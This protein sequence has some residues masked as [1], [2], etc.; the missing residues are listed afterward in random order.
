MAKQNPQPFEKLLEEFRT[1]R[2]KKDIDILTKKA[3]NWFRLNVDKYVKKKETTYSKGAELGTPTF[4]P[5]VGRFYLYKYDPKWKDELP[6]YDIMPLVLITSVT[7]NGWYGINFHYMPPI[8]RYKIMSEMYKIQSNTVWI[9]KKK[10][11]LSWAAAEK[12]GA[13]VGK[14][15]ELNHSIKQ[16]L[17]GHCRSALINIEPKHWDMVL[18]LPFQRFKFKDGAKPLYKDM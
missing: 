13:A 16:Y 12:I 5:V 2:N 9:E 7:E 4:T 1:Q 8:A 6:I 11:Q 15:K 18:F 14:S 10:I 17:S 3:L